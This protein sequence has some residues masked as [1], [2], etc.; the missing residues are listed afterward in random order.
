M[1]RYPLNVNVQVQ[2]ED[3]DD[4]IFVCDE[5]TDAFELDWQRDIDAI[6]EYLLGHIIADN[7]VIATVWYFYGGATVEEVLNRG[8]GLV[9]QFR[10]YNT[11]DVDDYNHL[12]EEAEHAAQYLYAQLNRTVEVYV[13]GGRPV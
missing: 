1:S 9:I 5:L 10:K 11:V 12:V 6:S 3:E 7:E 4:A 2:V 13:A 8:D